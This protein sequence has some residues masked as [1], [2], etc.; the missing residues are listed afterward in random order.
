M[1]KLALSVACLF[2]VSIV[3]IK[4][5]FA[6]SFSSPVNNFEIV[7]IFSP[8]LLIAFVTSLSELFSDNLLPSATE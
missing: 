5:G 8:F 2:I 7:L 3:P 6:E 4:P 1:S